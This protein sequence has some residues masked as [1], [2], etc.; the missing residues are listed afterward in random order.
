MTEKKERNME[1]EA[2]ILHAF[3]MKKHQT[4][5]LVEIQVSRAMIKSIRE[6]L[7]HIKSFDG[8]V[9]NKKLQDLARTANKEWAEGGKNLKRWV[10]ITE[11]SYRQGASHKMNI[12]LQGYG[13]SL[14]YPDVSYYSRVQDRFE[15][16]GASYYKKIDLDIYFQESD[17]RR[18]DHSKTVEMAEEY[19]KQIETWIEK[20]TPCTK[21]AHLERIFKRYKETKKEYQE[22]CDAFPSFIADSIRINRVY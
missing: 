5:A 20:I 15:A 18:Y 2:K 1:E 14:E 11:G 16:I 3:E 12:E 19:I 21:I 10:Y 9:I 22:A 4:Q 8:Y 7:E 6:S 17:S 13:V